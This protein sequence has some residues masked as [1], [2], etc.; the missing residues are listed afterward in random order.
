MT[1]PVNARN[2]QALHRNQRPNCMP[3]NGNTQTITFPVDIFSSA[4][5]ISAASPT[6]PS[7]IPKTLFPSTSP[8]YL[9]NHLRNSLPA[10]RLATHEFILPQRSNPIK[11]RSQ[12]QDH[13]SGN[14]TC[15]VRSNANPLYDG[16]DEVDCSAH[17]V[18]G[19]AADEVVEFA[20]G[21]T[22]AEEE[23]DF[24]EKDYEGACS[25]RGRVSNVDSRKGD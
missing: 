18:C 8:I 5:S 4:D 19:E 10:Q 23:R 13:G 11:A 14:K 22:D 21:G 17:V 9:N 2:S 7:P 24:Y 16:H 3:E 15:W 20:G 12:Q 6:S 25:V 1:Q